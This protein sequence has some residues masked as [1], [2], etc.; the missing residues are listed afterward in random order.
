MPVSFFVDPA[1]LDDPD[2]QRVRADHACPTRSTSIDAATA[3]CAA[4]RRPRPTA[5][6]RARGSRRAGHDEHL[7]PPTRC[8]T[9]AATTG[10]TK[11]HHPYHLVDPSPWP[12]VGSISALLLSGGVMWM[13]GDAGG[14]WVTLLGVLGV[15]STM[16]HWWRDVIREGRTGDHTEVVSKGLRIGMA[17]FITSEVLFFFAF[18]W[19]FFWGA[20]YPP[21][22]VAILA[23]RGR[24]PVAA[25]DIPFLN[26]LILLLSGCTVTWA[27]HACA[28][29]TSGPR[30]RRW[31]SLSAL[32]ILF[33]SFQAYEY[34]STIQP[35]ASR[36]GR[37]LRLDLLH[38]DGLPRLARHDRHH[39][40]IVCTDPRLLHQ[41]RPDK[42]V[43][44]R[45]R[46][47]VLALRRRGLAVPVRLGLLVGRQPALHHH[48]AALTDAPPSALAAGL[49]GRCPPAGGAAVRRLPCGGAALP[50]CGTDLSAQDSGDG[51]VAFI[52]LIVGASWS[53]RPARRGFVLWLAGVAAPAALA[54]AHRGFGPG[55]HASVQ[56]CADRAAVQAPPARL[57]RARLSCR[58]FLSRNRP[59]DGDRSARRS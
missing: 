14:L 19:A 59:G 1:M 47:L 28:R 15:L 56:G 58:G 3:S 33:T 6:S 54:A 35:R 27:H 53:L 22:T 57:R 43:G 7:R 50:A 2:T 39:F 55:A 45:G 48:P 36:S 44:L 10:T 37:D 5:T 32:G 23:A 26:T 13:H 30:S 4:G 51:P 8:T 52:V 34:I 46:R 16:V 41:F 49:T 24:E 18:F 11:P 40:L 38:G 31:C 12:I 21:A 29:T 25:W 42:H 9:H 17:L 20:L